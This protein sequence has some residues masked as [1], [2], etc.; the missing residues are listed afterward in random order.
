MSAHFLGGGEGIPNSTHVELEDSIVWNWVKISWELVMAS[1]GN[2]A[3]GQE[4][5]LGCYTSCWLSTPREPIQNTKSF[6]FGGWILEKKNFNR[7]QIWF[8]T[9]KKRHHWKKQGVNSHIILWT[10][11][12]TLIK[13]DHKTGW[14]ITYLKWPWAGLQYN[15]SNC[16]SLLHL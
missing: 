13:K 16:L 3:R 4:W 11:R 5:Q 6:T 1:N 10:V 12:T 2:V 9:L 14:L 15:Q 7:T 8:F